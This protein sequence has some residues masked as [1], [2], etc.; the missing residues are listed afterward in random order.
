MSTHS[1]VDQLNPLEQWNALVSGEACIDGFRDQVQAIGE[2]TIK[3]LH[4]QLSQNVEGLAVGSSSWSLLLQ[5]NGR[6]I[7][8]VRLT[9]VSDDQV[10]IDVES[11]IGARVHAALSRFL[12]RTKCEVTLIENVPVRRLTGTRG[13]S[14]AGA[15][16][17]TPWPGTDFFDLSDL[18]AGDELTVGA[19]SHEIGEAWMAQF[20]EPRHDADLH[21]ATLPSESG[22]IPASVAFGKGC[23]VGQELVER[24]DSRGR[25]LKS[26]MRV[27]SADTFAVDD[28]LFDGDTSVGKIT[29]ATEHPLGGC[30]GVALV[31]IAEDRTLLATHAGAAVELRALIENTI[32]E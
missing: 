20:A 23:Y 16:S 32:Y 27:K 30:V 3:F 4:G 11:G 13:A 31:K 24:I 26:L 18:G 17:C 2:D 21:D 25:V 12:L 1:Q 15:V 14:I 29:S 6:V 7:A 5:P 9:R 22:V 28:E 10:T 8:L 19:V